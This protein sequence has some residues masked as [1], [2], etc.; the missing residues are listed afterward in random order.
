MVSDESWNRESSTKKVPRNQTQWKGGGP[1]STPRH[2]SS[3]VVGHQQ[4]DQLPSLV[5]QAPMPLWVRCSELAFFLCIA[6]SRGTF[7]PCVCFAFS[8]LSAFAS[9]LGL[10]SPPQG[11]KVRY[12][13]SCPWHPLGRWSCNVHHRPRRTPP[14][15]QMISPPPC[16]SDPL[17]VSL[18]GSF[19]LI[20]GSLCQVIS[21]PPFLISWPEVGDR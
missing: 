16:W 5:C 12:P 21:P 1:L 10:L 20:G 7:I 6:S 13:S 3:S 18:V 9:Q 14:P 11:S 15:C 2:E 8:P 17:L 19:S 4:R